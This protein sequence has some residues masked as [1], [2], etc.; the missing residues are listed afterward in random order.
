M[1]ISPYQRRI[2]SFNYIKP[3]KYNLELELQ[4][5]Q[6]KQNTY[7]KNYKFLQGLKAQALN[8][9]FINEEAKGKVDQFNNDISKT[10][11]ELDG[12][13]GDLSNNNLAERYIDMFDKFQ[14]T[15]LVGLYKKETEYVNSLK[16]INKRKK[17]KKPGEAGYNPMNEMVYR[18]DLQEYAA[19]SM[20]DAKDATV[21][22]YVPYANIGKLQEEAL[23]KVPE[24]ETEYETTDADGLKTTVNIKG[25]DP[26][27]SAKISRRINAEN[28]AQLKVQAKYLYISGV[29]NDPE[30]L[31][32]QLTQYN[33]QVLAQRNTLLAQRAD[34]NTRYTGQEKDE[35]YHNFNQ[36]IENGLASLKTYGLDDLDEDKTIG[37]I[38]NNLSSEITEAA[39]SAYAP[40]SKSVTTDID[41]M[42]KFE[43]EFSIKTANLL[44]SQ[45]KFQHQVN[46]DAIE[47]QFSKLDLELKG[48]KIGK[49]G[50][51]LTGKDTD[52]F[53][54]S[55]ATKDGTTVYTPEEVK[56]LNEK[57]T[58]EVRT[59]MIQH[60]SFD[61]GSLKL[62]GTK[63]AEAL[64]V[65]KQEIQG[66]LNKMRYAQESPLY[67]M[68]SDAPTDAKELL[69]QLAHIDDLISKPLTKDIILDKLIDN[70]STFS[71]DPMLSS[72]VDVL[73]YNEA[74]ID[75]TTGNNKTSK[76]L[77]KAD[78][79][80]RAKELKED[81]N[82]DTSLRQVELD[83][84]YKVFTEQLGKI[85]VNSDNFNTQVEGLLK[86]PNLKHD[87]YAGKR[88]DLQGK[89]DVDKY[90][91]SIAKNMLVDNVI[92]GE[93]TTL[94]VSG[95]NPSDLASI[96]LYEN[97]QTKIVLDDAFL[98]K[99]KKAERDISIEVKDSEGLPHV[100]K[101]SPVNNQ[102][103]FFRDR[104]NVLDELAN[105]ADFIN[106]S[107]VHKYGDYNY[108]LATT[109]QGTT[110]INITRPDGTTKSV[111]LNASKYKSHLDLQTAAESILQK[112]IIEDGRKN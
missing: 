82:S 9:Q 86:N 62:E 29:L 98:Q 59:V 107:K 100:V 40:Q 61:K 4:V 34:L 27:T 103:I 54:S 16:D 91:Q 89:T 87:L 108:T 92:V 67:Y 104:V 8:I 22:S 60:H 37:I 7:D 5:L 70:P 52:G 93:N 64:K 101:L 73:A 41:P 83:R 72:N 94:N 77:V 39:V 1:R 19:L 25:R 49:D 71:Q 68:T 44:L 84:Y 105:S 88:I 6:H 17:S 33:N 75:L 53:I 21:D 58:D 3:P 30:V 11:D 96:E 14:K 46:Q 66:E 24:T 55:Y 36:Q 111:R 74:I 45:E 15:D 35:A 47:N 42:F 18:S 76:D 56:M 31:N 51:L 20:E 97:G 48:L 26:L 10:F 43:K 106:R 69:E 109:G 99:Q 78:I 23:L 65:K 79:E 102:I 50:S 2:A 28:A 95:L 81:P 80:K 57:L 85:D 110:K 112:L 38:S 12:N 13:F 63:Y 90:H 32:S